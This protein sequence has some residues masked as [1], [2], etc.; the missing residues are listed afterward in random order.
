MLYQ[1]LSARIVRDLF[2]IDTP[3]IR[4]FRTMYERADH[5]LAVVATVER[6]L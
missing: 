6:D 4:A 2:Q 1:S 3:E 5:R